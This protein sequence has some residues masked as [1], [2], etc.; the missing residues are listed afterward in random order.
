MLF[1]VQYSFIIVFKKKSYEIMN[2]NTI[3]SVLCKTVNRYKC[4]T[5]LDRTVMCAIVEMRFKYESKCKQILLKCL[6][7]N[8]FSANV[9]EN[10]LIWLQNI[11]C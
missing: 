7:Y 1:L 5:I 11:C 4:W 2:F 9:L 10:D 8:V 6:P 3:A